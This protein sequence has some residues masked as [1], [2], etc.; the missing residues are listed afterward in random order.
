MPSFTFRPGYTHIYIY[1]LILTLSGES[2]LKF[3]PSFIWGLIR[4]RWDFAASLPSRA[5]CSQGGNKGNI[6][7]HR[8]QTVA[9]TTSHWCHHKR[10]TLLELHR[11][12][13]PRILL[14][15]SEAA[16]GPLSPGVH[17]PFCGRSS[18]GIK[19]LAVSP[20]SQ[21]SKSPDALIHTNL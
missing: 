8:Q 16:A 13:Y 19:P 11:L 5:V 17:L 4:S 1:N 12:R 3:G 10:V 9:M 7:F 6:T 2:C 14:F 20:N 18:R 15:P 21:S